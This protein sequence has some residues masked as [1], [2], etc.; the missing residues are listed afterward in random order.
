MKEVLIGAVAV[1]ALAF[2]FSDA[3]TGAVFVQCPEGYSYDGSHGYCVEL[4][5]FEENVKCVVENGVIKRPSCVCW[6]YEDKLLCGFEGNEKLSFKSQ[7]CTRQGNVGRACGEYDS[8][9]GMCVN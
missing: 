4:V 9:A 3:L 8:R 1:L 5:C 2:L 6:R 7:L